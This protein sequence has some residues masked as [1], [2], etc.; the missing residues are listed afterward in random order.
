MLENRV[1]KYQG[2]YINTSEE[3]LNGHIYERSGLMENVSVMPV[4]GDKVLFMH[5]YRGYEK[6][7]RWKLV[8]G[9]CDKKHLSVI[10]HGQ[11]ELAEELGL[12]AAQ[13]SEIYYASHFN[14]T[15][16]INSHYLVC[17]DVSKLE[18]PVENPDSGEEVLDSA[19][20]S[21]DMIIEKIT[22]GEMILDTDVAVVLWFLKKTE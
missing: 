21:F 14:A 11:E 13:W 12:Q 22:A 3:S 19:W 17:R 15:L 2:K 8:T 1:S 5:E 4:E 7:S 16:D 6:R 9:W 18:Y 20:L 10:E